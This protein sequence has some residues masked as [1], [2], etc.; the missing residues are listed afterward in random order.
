[1]GVDWSSIE[2]FISYM[3]HVS[4]I[5]TSWVIMNMTLYSQNIIAYNQHELNKLQINKMK[6]ITYL[7]MNIAM[8]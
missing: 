7:I 6:I 4:L 8:N 1:M 5:E 3:W 2:H